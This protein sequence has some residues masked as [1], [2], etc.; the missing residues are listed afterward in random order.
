MAEDVSQKLDGLERA[1]KDQIKEGIAAQD[2][3]TRGILARNI[4]RYY[5]A[6]LLLILLG[7]P[8]YNYLMISAANKPM[9][10]LSIKDSLLTYSAIVGPT[11]GVVLGYYFKSK[12]D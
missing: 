3:R 4:V 12:A 1:G 2:N 8:L 5:F 6:L 11:V 7:V 10:M 9:L